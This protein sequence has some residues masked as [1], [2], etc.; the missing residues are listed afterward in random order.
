MMKIETNLKFKAPNLNFQN[1]LLFIAERIVIPQLQKNIQNGIQ[2][3]ATPF[4]ALEPA[5]IRRKA[6]A[7]SDR[8]F[9]KKGNIRNSAIK[10]V[11][12]GGLKAFSVKTLI[13]TGALLS[14]FFARKSGKS[15]VIVSISPARKEIGRFLQIEGVGS[16][17]KKFNFFGVSTFM[18]Q[19][20]IRYMKERIS[21]AIRSAKR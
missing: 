10:T 15:L 4:P 5:T 7:V 1:D 17:N 20:A 16:K 9:T 6:G 18:E 19:D 14:S 11:G 21:A 13:E 3:D 12:A 8:L 2:V